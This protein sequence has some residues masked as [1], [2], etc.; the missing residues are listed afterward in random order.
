MNRLNVLIFAAV[1]GLGVLVTLFILRSAAHEET[2]VTPRHMAE[3]RVPPPLANL[4]QE[5]PKEAVLPPAAPSNVQHEESSTPAWPDV[6]GGRFANITPTGF[7]IYNASLKWMDNQ[8]NSPGLIKEATCALN[9]SQVL[10]MA[11]PE[12]GGRYSNRW[13][14]AIGKEIKDNAGVVVSLGKSRAS[15]VKGL[16]QIYN[17]YLPTGAII[18]ACYSPICGPTAEHPTGARHVAIVGEQIDDIIYIHHNNYYRPMKGEEWHPGMISQSYLASGI[19]RQWQRSPWL[20][21]VRGPKGEVVRFVV[22]APAMLR[23][24]NPYQAHINIAIPREIV[25]DVDAGRAY[26][27]DRKGLYRQLYVHGTQLVR[28]APQRHAADAVQ[29]QKENI[30]PPP[31]PSRA[32]A[33][34]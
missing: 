25:K 13:A 9:V 18:T 24:M 26:A 21:L 22:V 14:P 15:I 5:A 28:L 3:K 10:T 17:G 34:Q 16:R 30:P 8:R 20:R 19:Y 7:A 12:L 11:G 4:P 23:I 32:L 33:A 1:A 31:A 2:A 6:Q 29:S 27:V